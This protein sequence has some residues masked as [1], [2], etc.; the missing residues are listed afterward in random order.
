MGDSPR[1][2]VSKCDGV[3][4]HTK[5][6]PLFRNGF[7]KAQDGG[8]GRGVVGLADVTV[9]PRDAGD[10]G[11]AAILGGF[12]RF[13]LDAH[14]RRCGA[15]ETEGRADVDFHDDVPCVVRH[16][17]QH[18]V[19]G[20]TSCRGVIMRDQPVKP[21]A[22]KKKR[23]WNE[24]PARNVPLLTMWFNLPYRLEKKK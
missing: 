17:V 13:R 2:N 3:G 11:D 7:G 22:L 23:V 10:V 15:N 6:A 5:G 20:K 19:I 9:E 16:R 24:Q 18:A 21:A 4:T 1:Q 8:F 14:K 12:A